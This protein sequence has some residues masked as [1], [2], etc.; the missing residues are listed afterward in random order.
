MLGRTTGDVDR[1]PLVKSRSL[2]ERGTRR[3]DRILEILCECRG[4]M[5]ERPTWDLDIDLG[6]IPLLRLVVVVKRG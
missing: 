2:R 5:R 1:H 3:T 6:R 4:L